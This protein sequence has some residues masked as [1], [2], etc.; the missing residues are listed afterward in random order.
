MALSVQVGADHGP[1]SAETAQP[2]ELF[3][4]SGR[5]KRPGVYRAPV[6]ITARDLIET[7]GGGMEDV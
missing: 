5:V 6:G 4:L 1:V 3:S 7:H 2:E